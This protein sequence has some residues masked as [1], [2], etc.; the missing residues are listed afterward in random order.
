MNG[1]L[2]A[3]DGDQFIRP[4]QVRGGNVKGIHRPQAGFACFTERHIL[5]P[6]D[7]PAPFDGRI[8]EIDLIESEFGLSFEVNRLGYRFQVEKWACEENPVGVLKDG[9]RSLPP[10]WFTPVSGYE[11]TAVEE[12]PD[13]HSPRL[14]G[15]AAFSDFALN[16]FRGK[17]PTTFGLVFFGNLAKLAT[18]FR[19]AVIT[20]RGCL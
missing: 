13:W 10:A 9:K 2:H 16:F 19:L 3:L 7:V 18:Q 15:S 11:N 6:L 4:K 14:R 8:V 1:L 5:N 17:E 20:V 12:G